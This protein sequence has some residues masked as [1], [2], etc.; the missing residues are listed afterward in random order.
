VQGK[1]SPTVFCAYTKD[2]DWQTRLS[3]SDQ[4]AGIFTYDVDGYDSYGYDKDDIDRAG[5]SEYDYSAWDVD[6][7]NSLAYS[8][9]FD[10]TRP[11][12]GGLTRPVKRDAEQ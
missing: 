7:F 10:G 4:D 3:E 6:Q 12:L 2:P 1:Y 8:W 5:N 11:V 9:S